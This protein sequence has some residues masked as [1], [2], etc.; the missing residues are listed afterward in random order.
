LVPLTVSVPPT[1]RQ[2]PP[3]LLNGESS[4]TS[5]LPVM[6]RPPVTLADPPLCRRKAAAT[7]A[8]PVSFS[9]APS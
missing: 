1:T 3:P 6:L 4:H 2:L 5:P 9:A 7:A 8:V